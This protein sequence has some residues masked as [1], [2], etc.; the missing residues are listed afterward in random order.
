MAGEIDILIVDDDEDI[1]QFME[2]LLSENGYRATTT[3]S[4]FGALDHLRDTSVHFHCVVLDVRLP[5]ISGIELLEEIRQIDKD[6]PIIMVTGNPTVE[7]AVD[8][9]KHGVSDYIQKPFDNDLF[10]DTLS[11]ILRERGVLLDS[12]E[13]LHKTIG[14]TIRAKRKEHNLTLK[15]LSQRT[16][17][18]VS[19]ISQIERAESS[20]SVASLYKLANA[21]DVPITELFGDH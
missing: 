20:A 7:T 21:L 19:L 11:K 8:S 17:L 6:V 18:S 12:I 2:T 4:P 13:M 16:G 15:Q 3:T 10:I 9:L 14:S 5:D 1:C